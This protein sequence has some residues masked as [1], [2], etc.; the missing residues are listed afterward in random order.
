MSYPVG[1]ANTYN[2]NMFDTISAKGYKLGFSF[3]AIINK[4]PQQNRF[5]L[6]RLSIDQPFN[7]RQLMEMILSAE[8]PA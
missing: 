1:G 6:G 7:K 3:R 8:Q 5:E 4:N 2:R